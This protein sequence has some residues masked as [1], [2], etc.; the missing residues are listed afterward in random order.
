MTMLAARLLLG[1][2]FAVAALTK[3]ADRGGVRRAV[4]AF[5]VPR[6]AAATLG[7]ILT[8]IE[9]GIA[10]LLLTAPKVGGAVALITLIGFSAVV[11][12]SLARG[13]RLDCHCFGRLSSGP[14]GW[15]TLARNG[16]FAA[17]ATFI[18]LDGHFGW[19]ITAFATVM[20]A[21][22]IGPASRRRWMA[23]AG[24]TAARLALPDRAGKIW[25]LDKR[26]RSLQ[27]C[28]CQVP[29]PDGEERRVADLQRRMRHRYLHFD[30]M[31]GRNSRPA[32]RRPVPQGDESARS[33]SQLPQDLSRAA[34]VG[35]CYST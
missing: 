35:R 21:L 32:R 31:V 16:S 30:D 8:A 26:D 12:V 6:A 14:L 7:S 2:M 17:L 5:G 23:R 9:L 11:P 34:S 19:P 28:R 29:M 25:T 24:T 15:P 33:A 18:A 3:L 1:G 27:P 13:Q 10:A 4:V 20:L 22:W